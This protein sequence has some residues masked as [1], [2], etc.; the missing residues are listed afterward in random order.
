MLAAELVAIC[1]RCQSQ[2]QQDMVDVVEGQG[3]TRLANLLRLVDAYDL[4]N[5]PD[6]VATLLAPTNEVSLLGR[7]G[8]RA[9]AGLYYVL[10][11]H[12]NA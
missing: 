10:T 5:S 12:I 6:P 1:V 11:T 9:R 3:L 4:A 2:A 8:H 7:R